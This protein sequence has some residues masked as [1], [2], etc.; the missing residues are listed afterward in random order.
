VPDSETLEFEPGTLIGSQYRVGR[1]LGGGGMG[2][3]YKCHDIALQR[4]VAIKFLQPH[5]A[6]TH[7]GL[8]RLQQEARALSKLTDPTIVKVHHLS[9]TTDS[10]P[11]YLVMDYLEGRSL[12]EIIKAEHTLDVDRCLHIMI[13]IVTGLSH[14][15]RLGIVHRDL[16]PAN[17]M[18]VVQNGFETAKILDFGMAKILYA[19]DEPEQNVTRTGE[20]F[21]TP[22]Y[23]SPEQA[24]GKTVDDRT[25]QYSLGC[26]LFEC[27]TGTPPHVGGTAM[28]TMIRHVT[29]EVDP[30]S[31]ASLGKKFSPRLEALVHRLLYK[32][33]SKRFRNMDEVR[34]ELCLILNQEP[35]HPE[36][37]VDTDARARAGRV[38]KI[39]LKLAAIVFGLFF[40]ITSGAL[41]MQQKQQQ[42]QQQQQQQARLVAE[43]RQRAAAIGAMPVTL[44]ML[45]RGEMRDAPDPS[46]PD[47]NEAGGEFLRYTEKHT[48]TEYVNLHNERFSYLTDRG[49]AAI[50]RMPNVRWLNLTKCEYIGDEGVKHL[51]KFKLLMLDLS[52]TN[53]TDG[54]LITL[55]PMKSLVS[56][57]FTEDGAITNRG[58]KELQYFPH[59]ARIDLEKTSVDASGLADIAKCK[60]LKILDLQHLQ[61]RNGLAALQALPDLQ[62]LDL[63]GTD[64]LDKDLDALVPIKSLRKVTIKSTGISGR[65]LETLA[66]MQQLK[67]ICLLDALRL[68]KAQIDDLKRAMPK[69]HI[70]C[71]AD[72]P[73]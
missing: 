54:V 14:A 57:N 52:R 5:L 55:R 33:P 38:R 37:F 40:A 60:T 64:I 6:S 10:V 59:L 19:M 9:R 53:V 73:D 17:I 43:K 35:L 32:D 49:L 20:I 44:K 45:I 36:T 72:D 7:R 13:E 69:C 30:L 47:F 42:E 50:E 4:T 28:E 62:E 2:V 71:D 1:K 26:M 8:V 46:D 31:Q 48:Y 16:K 56:L 21:G 39:H 67:Q 51:L 24:V 66:R 23:M 15:H 34:D 22:A 70:R 29:E 41:V 63:S 3:V 25:D 65:G 58:M 61:I 11:P 68:N 12:A 18:L 27:L